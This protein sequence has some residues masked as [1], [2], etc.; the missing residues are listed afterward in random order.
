VRGAQRL[1]NLRHL[2]RCRSD[3][4]EAIVLVAQTSS[5]FPK[6]RVRNV[7]FFY[8][9]FQALNDISLKCTRNRSRL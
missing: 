8:G 6:L 5:E 4:K 1:P 7:N 3:K 9:A 2:N